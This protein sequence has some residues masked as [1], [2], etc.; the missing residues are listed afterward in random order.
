MYPV[1]ANENVVIVLGMHRS[2]TSA[3]AAG[4][5]QLGLVMGSSLF[6]G[7]EWNPKGYF[8]EREIVQFNERLLA[9]YD[10]RWDSPLPPLLE[11]DHRWDACIDEAMSLVRVLFDEVPA[12][13]FKDP[14]MCQLAPFWGQVFSQ[15]GIKPRLMIVVRD[16]AEVV[17]SLA[18]RDG[19]SSDR[20]AWLWMTH[21]LGAMEYLDVADDIR[22]FAFDHM[23]SQPATFLSD[24]AGWLNLK[25]ASETIAHFARDFIAPALSHGA[26]TRQAAL[27]SLVLQAYESVRSAI[28]RGL[29]P[30]AL[31][32]SFEWQGIISEYRRDIIPTLTSVQRFFQNDRQLSVMELRI[33][34]LS[35]GLASAE[36]LALDRLEEMQKLDTQLI[37]TSDALAR[38]EQIV[39]RQ[40]EELK[41]RGDA[42]SRPNEFESLAVERLKQVQKLDGQLSQMSAELA[43]AEQIVL[44]QQGVLMS[45][46]EEYARFRETELARFREIELL[47]I[48]RLEHMQKLDAQLI[49]TSA[50]LALAE[51]VVSEQQD[52]FKRKDELL[53][54]FEETQLLAIERLAQMQKLDAQL[55]LTSDALAYAEKIVM[56]QQEALAHAN[57][58][59]SSSDEA[60][61]P[62]SESLQ[63]APKL[64]LKV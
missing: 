44:E 1:D 41:L 12:W 47:A 27:P 2:G 58:Q 39:L 4:L 7:D 37:E 49:E 24:V 36:K 34:A 63:D 38:A 61:V 32:E 11:R 55:L 64:D 40:Q 60:P 28:E 6:K 51:R 8:E 62:A 20:A 35:K 23:L 52:A 5:E 54:L 48:E 22:F 15:L 10:C 18:R 14:R 50:A 56:E 43:H 46:N 29:T 13:G 45:Q 26:G 42:R 59:A 33:S 57:F 17:H 53:A 25:P 9:L 31:R 16:P 21:L 3:I 30:R 19:I